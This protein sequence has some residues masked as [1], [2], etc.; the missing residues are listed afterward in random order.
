MDPKFA[1]RIARRISDVKRKKGVMAAQ[2]EVVDRLGIITNT[3][4]GQQVLERIKYWK[5]KPLP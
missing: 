3:P 2:E 1:D 5:D 4:D